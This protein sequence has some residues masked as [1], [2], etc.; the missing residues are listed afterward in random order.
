[1]IGPVVGH[2]GTKVS[3]LV[4]G[5]LPPDVADRLWTHVHCCP[6]CRDQVER[7][8]WVK[9]RVAELS[10]HRRPA[11]DY[12]TSL[13]SLE[14]ADLAAAD[15]SPQPQHAATRRRTTVAA[16]VG[17]GSVGA[18]VL[19]VLAVAGPAATPVDR[20]A[21]VADFSNP[22]QPAGPVQPINS[23]APSTVD[24]VL[25]PAVVLASKF[26]LGQ[27]LSNG[28]VTISK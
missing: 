11:P 5:Q 26:F 24:D 25:L 19:G 27:A 13:L 9:T 1:M 3:A 21:P 20:R 12:L 14:P 18:A 6:L 8:G 16:V 2:V 4:D 28:W 17:A 7:E 15:K 23:T 22:S 10:M